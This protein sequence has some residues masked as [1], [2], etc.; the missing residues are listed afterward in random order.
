MMMIVVDNK[1]DC[2]SRVLYYICFFKVDDNFL[3]LRE[4]CFQ[5]ANMA[6]EAGFV[7]MNIVTRR[8]VVLQNRFSVL[9][10]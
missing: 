8:K 10:G 6:T 2:H 3:Q 4:M 1:S 9:A 7:C 5:I